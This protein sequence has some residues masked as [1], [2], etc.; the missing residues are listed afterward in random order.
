ATLLL[1]LAHSGVSDDDVRALDRRQRDLWWNPQRHLHGSNG[2]GQLLSE[3]KQAWIGRRRATPGGRRG[4][5]EDPADGTARVR[6]LTDDE[7]RRPHGALRDA[8]RQRAVD[9]VRRR[10]DY[11]F[12][13]YPGDQLATFLREFVL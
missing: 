8:R 11:A 2:P 4:R 12:C 6:P 9:R 10:R 5:F 7:Y 1:P 3:E 13:L